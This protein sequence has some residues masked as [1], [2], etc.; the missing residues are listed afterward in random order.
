MSYAKIRFTFPEVAA[1]TPGSPTFNFIG[2][3]GN[4]INNTSRCIA[5]ANHI[6]DFRIMAMREMM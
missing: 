6:F 4:G 5:Q 2:D 1:S 3:G